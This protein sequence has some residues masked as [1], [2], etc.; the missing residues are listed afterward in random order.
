MYMF[1]QKNSGNINR[2]GNKNTSTAHSFGNKNESHHKITNHQYQEEKKP[3]SDLEKSNNTTQ[4]H[5][6]KV[7]GHIY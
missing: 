1:G 3:H 6:M 4:Q 7:L 5:Q 2:F